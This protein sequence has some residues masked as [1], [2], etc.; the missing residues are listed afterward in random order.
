MHIKST[1]IVSLLAGLTI[2][3]PAPS[4]AT[5]GDYVGKRSEAAPG[6]YVGKRLEAAPGDYV[7]KRSEAA[8]GD[9]VGKR[10]SPGEPSGATAIQ[11]GEIN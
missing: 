7:G 4:K 8:P 2:A 5:P 1:I 6:D 11:S 3:A 10:G 9:Y